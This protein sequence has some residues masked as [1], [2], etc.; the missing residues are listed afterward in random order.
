MSTSPWIE[1]YRPKD[2][3]DIK[4]QNI[5]I[6]CI[7]KLLKNN[8]LPHLLFYGKSGTGKT[9]TISSIINKLFGNN[10]VFNL[11]K[12]D[13]SDDRGINSVREEIKGFA[14]KKNLFNKG[15]KIIILDEADNMTFD[16][17]FALRRIIEKHSE[18]T[19]FCLICNYENKI[20][21]AIKSR[22]A[23]FKFNPISKDIIYEKLFEICK[24]EKIVIKKRSLKTISELSNGDLRKSINLL[25][26]VYLKDKT[27]KQKS[28]YEIAGIPSDK[29][30]QKFIDIVNSNFS[31]SSKIKKAGFI[32]DEGYSLSVILEKYYQY[33]YNNG[34]FRNKNYPKLISDLSNIENFVAKS[35]FAEIYFAA[36][37][38]VILKYQ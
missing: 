38:A 7:K 23:N 36:F 20:I 4:G 32:L 27:I 17:Q 18:N 26:S 30:F 1:K 28:I 11:M 6:E 5:N 16:A 19:R 8:S 31:L 2:L 15:I 33:I 37:I 29:V 21:P 25:Q 3:D 12:L 13:A 14:E 24:S 9:S 22:C 34:L 10:K 35:T